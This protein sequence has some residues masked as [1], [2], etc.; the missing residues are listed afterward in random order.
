MLVST[1]GSSMVW[2]FLVFNF[3]NLLENRIS[4]D[5]RIVV[6]FV[7]VDEENSVIYLRNNQRFVEVP[8]VRNLVDALQNFGLCLYPAPGQSDR[9]GAD[10]EEI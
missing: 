10:S 7:P 4:E 5:L 1:I 9:I 3:P 6:A 8:L 2:P